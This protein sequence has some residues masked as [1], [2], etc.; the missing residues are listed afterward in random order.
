VPLAALLGI[1]CHDATVRDG[2][3]SMVDARGLDL[4]IKVTPNWYF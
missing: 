3:Q 4:T 1:G 2:L